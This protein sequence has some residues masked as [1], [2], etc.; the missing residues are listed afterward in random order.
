MHPDYTLLD[1]LG[2]LKA[3]IL[4]TPAGE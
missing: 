1:E 2:F 3:Y 4:E